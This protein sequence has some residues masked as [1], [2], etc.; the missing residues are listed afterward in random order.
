MGSL[1]RGASV[2]VVF[3]FEDVHHLIGVE[4]EHTLHLH[5]VCVLFS[6]S[7]LHLLLLRVMVTLT[8]TD[9]P[10]VPT[11]T[12]EEDYDDKPTA[13]TAVNLSVGCTQSEC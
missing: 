9:P 7:V 12:E 10:Q 3:R 8:L 6:A 13:F 2:H 4:F 1:Q 5:A 11:Q